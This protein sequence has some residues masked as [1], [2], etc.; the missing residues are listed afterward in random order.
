MRKFDFKKVLLVLLALLMVFALVACND[1]SIEE[2]EGGGPI[3]SGE[4]AA[5]YFTA[6]WNSAKSIGTQPIGQYDDIKFALG[7]QLSVAVGNAKLNLGIGVEAIY[8]RANSESDNDNIGLYSAAKVKIYNAENNANLLTAYYFMDEPT[9]IYVDSLDQKFY[10]AFDAT[11][12]EN[13]DLYSNLTKLLNNDY[14]SIGNEDL[15]VDDI[16]NRFVATFGPNFSLE[17]I[18][19]VLLEML[20]LNLK[21]LLDMAA[22]IISSLKTDDGSTKL[23]DV[24][25]KQGHLVI[26]SVDKRTE[27]DGSITWVG[28]P[29]NLVYNLASGFT[30]ELIT[31]GAATIELVFNTNAAGNDINYFAVNLTRSNLGSQRATLAASIKINQLSVEKVTA[32]AAANR[33]AFG[34]NTEN[35]GADYALI[36]DL[37]VSVAD[38]MA[39]ITLGNDD[40]IS[41][42]EATIEELANKYNKSE[43]V[44]RIVEVNKQALKGKLT[45][46]LVGRMDLLK[47]SD[48]SKAQLLIYYNE[49]ETSAQAGNLVVKAVFTTEIKN[50][51]T[52]GSV[53]IKAVDMNN[54]Y[55]RIARDYF[56][57]TFIKA[58]DKDV[59]DENPSEG[60]NYDL[61][62]G[63]FDALINDA[64]QIEIVGFEPQVMFQNV[65]FGEKEAKSLSEL[66]MKTFTALDWEAAAI[67]DGWVK[68]QDGTYKK[69]TTNIDGDEVE[70]TRS[71]EQLRKIT[72]IS[73]RSAYPLDLNILKIAEIAVGAFGKSGN[74]YSVIV[75]NIANYVFAKTIQGGKII[76]LGFM[77]TMWKM[78][79]KNIVYESAE[80]I[81]EWFAMVYKN[82]SSVIQR[83]TD[84]GIIPAVGI[85]AVSKFESGKFNVVYRN[86][87]LTYVKEAKEVNNGEQ[88]YVLSYKYVSSE[89]V[90]AIIDGVTYY[91]Q[92]GSTITKEQALVM[93]AVAN[94]DTAEERQ[95]VLATINADRTAN[96]A[97][98]LEISV[99]EKVYEESLSAAMYEM[100]GGSGII[101]EA[102]DVE[103]MLNALLSGDV[104]VSIGVVDGAFKV[105]ATYTK[106]GKSASVNLSLALKANQTIDTSFDEW[107]DNEDNK[108]YTIDTSRYMPGN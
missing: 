88:V 25:T 102:A 7:A 85:K 58:L 89:Q 77:N 82:S 53:K 83:M 67:A 6:L 50:G 84:A 91:Y 55:V 69:V 51:K 87:K 103:G 45:A 5:N 26:A 24:L 71:A 8:D 68:Q 63:A 48:N 94:A 2:D 95:N 57:V 49:D 54:A 62:V 16:I 1:D 81:N 86:N 38:A 105:T 59:P 41:S 34:I 20:G 64:D 12:S 11:G 3:S 46:K 99:I 73:G 56:L 108:T 76:Q 9:K 70:E 44:S 21:D 96:N 106:S 78:V 27:S 65:F 66:Q 80:N 98:E 61:I 101:G 75:N 32:G 107:E 42:N 23:I 35:Y 17:D 52:V 10:L 18:I 72:N 40:V 60:E 90:G 100:F 15:S 31:S 19:S 104:S 36:A 74:E 37:S 79:D 29:A 4:T 47:A 30:D 43:A 28:K 92:N 93:W 39:M 97:Q 13:D 22:S 33:T 14:F